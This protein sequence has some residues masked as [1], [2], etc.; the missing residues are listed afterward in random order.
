MAE[1]KVIN[2]EQVPCIGAYQEYPLDTPVIA[3]VSFYEDGGRD[4]GCPKLGGKGDPQVCNAHSYRLRS[5]YTPC[6]HLFPQRNKR[7]N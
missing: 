2:A 7:G 5:Q 4:V 6:I 3:T 1:R